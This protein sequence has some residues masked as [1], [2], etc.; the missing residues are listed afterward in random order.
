MHQSIDQVNHAEVYL[1]PL[2]HLL[3]YEEKTEIDNEAELLSQISILP[4][5]QSLPLAMHPRVDLGAMRHVL[6]YYLLGTYRKSGV[7]SEQ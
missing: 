4:L 6:L 2:R 5:L 1:P 7:C 3:V